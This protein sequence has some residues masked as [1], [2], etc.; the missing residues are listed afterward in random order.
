VTA[1]RLELVQ[2]S[3]EWLAARADGIGSSDM[4]VIAGESPYRS[5]LELWAEKTG[6][7]GPAEIEPATR[8]L[9]DI[10]KRM[11]PV[12]LD[13]YEA[14][15]GR[16]ARRAPR[17]LA[18]PEIPWA[19]ASLD[20][21]APV[22]RIVEA[23]WTHARRW[24][25]GDPVPADVLIQVQWQ[26]FVT[27][28]RVV[29][30]VALVGPELRIVEIGRDEAMIDDLLFLAADFWQH[31]QDGTPPAVDGSESTR[32]AL[33]RIHPANDGTMLAADPEVDAVVAD[34]IA[35]KAEAKALESHVGSLENTLRALIGDADGI[36]GSWG[37]LT[38]KRNADSTRTNWPAVAEAYRLRLLES[39]TDPDEIEAVQS[40][41]T[42]TVEGARVLRLSQKGSTAA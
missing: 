31:V 17:M 12:L 41:H 27:G 14:E 5:P 1:T 3:A 19:R 15:T 23:K 11:E 32:R 8:K 38:W 10:G 9:M 37:R 7:V 28:R 36:A 4:P 21:E 34:L 35:A 2:G 33:A 20:A 29:D 6:K 30:V 24:S 16:K 39:G 22:R 42:G 25:Q 13:L 26:M 18:H 40:I